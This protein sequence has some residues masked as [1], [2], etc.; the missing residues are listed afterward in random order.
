MSI[1]T[2]EYDKSQQTLTFAHF[3]FL[4]WSDGFLNPIVFSYE[5]LPSLICKTLLHHCI[6]ISEGNI[7]I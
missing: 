3:R 4:E 6:S 2:S 5:D 7:I 1:K